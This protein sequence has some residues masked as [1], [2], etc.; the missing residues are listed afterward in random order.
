MELTSFESR[1]TFLEAV[2]LCK[3][4]FLAALSIAETT[5][6][7]AA[8]ALS[9]LLFLTSF[10]TFFDK[11]FIMFLTDLFFRVLTSVCLARLMADL[12]F[13]GAAFAG[14]VLPPL[15]YFKFKFI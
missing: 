2:F 5:V 8:S 4:L 12:F 9:L 6:V 11:V 10:S 15:I 3:T 14:N 13:L 7:K 1:E